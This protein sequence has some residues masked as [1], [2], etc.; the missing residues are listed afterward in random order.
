M[1]LVVCVI[2]SVLL[3]MSLLLF[4][5][6]LNH[7]LELKE[8]NTILVNRNSDLIEINEKIEKKCFNL[9]LKL[10]KLEKTKK[11]TKKTT[12]KETKKTSKKEDK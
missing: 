5:I 4:I 12:K 6:C 9:E 1:L 11:E 2:L 8:R 7:Y 10:E 3:F